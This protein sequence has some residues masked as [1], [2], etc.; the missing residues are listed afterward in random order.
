M[1]DCRPMSTPQVPSSS[2]N[3]VSNNLPSE[4]VSKNYFRAIGLLNYQ[5]TCTHQDLAFSASR[6][7]HFLINPGCE[8]ELAFMHVLWYFCGTSTWG[9]TLGKVGDNSMISSFCDSD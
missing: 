2:L 5:V 1:N 8:H 7:S 3:P 4:E 6:I 9:I